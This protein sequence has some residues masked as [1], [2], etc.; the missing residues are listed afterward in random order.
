VRGSIVS[1]VVGAVSGNGDQAVA[2]IAGT[3]NGLAEQATDT[4]FGSIDKRCAPDRADVRQHLSVAS[5]QALLQLRGVA[6]LAAGRVS[7]VLAAIVSVR[8]MTTVLSPTDVGRYLIL[9]TFS[10]W[11]SLTLVSPVGNY[12]NRCFIGWVGRGQVWSKLLRYLNLLLLVCAAATGASF[13]AY[14][15]GVLG[16]SIGVGGLILVVVGLLAFLTINTTLVGLLNLL[17]HRNLYVLYTSATAWFAVAFSVAFTLGIQRSAELWIAGQVV[18]W[19]LVGV[20]GYL[21]LRRRIAGATPAT[22]SESS[23]GAGLWAFAWPLV[24]STSLYWFQVQGYRIELEHWISVSA[25]GLLTTGILLGANPVATIDTLL[26]EYLRPQYYRD[27]ACE[28]REMQEA[29]WA[30]LASSFLT[31]LIPIA[32]LTGSAGSFLAVLLVAPA[33]QSV[34]ALISWG[35]LIELLRAVNSLYVLA[36]HTRFKTRT[37]LAPAL[38]GAALVLVSIVPLT[39][40]NLYIGSG[41]ALSIAML[42]STVYLALSLRNT[43]TARLPY[44]S[45]VKAI[46]CSAPIAL[47]L[48]GAQ[49]TIQHPS[50]LQAVAVL[51][52]A[53]LATLVALIVLGQMPRPAVAQA[54]GLR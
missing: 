44:R 36:A 8:L 28:D 9:T 27:V 16:I 2:P 53:S 7:I 20:M 33:F 34:A 41:L 46:C 30:R 21:S 51:I 13:V 18:A 42:G 31:S 23:G 25:V 39:R 40:W 11:F 6:L 4:G 10:M 14:R 52:V 17:G 5:L 54:P 38:V 37:T 50:P 19:A 26:G 24:I 32:V 22:P 43:F 45:I 12:I 47:G 35:V 48:I 1:D 29:A 15:T 3:H 49:A